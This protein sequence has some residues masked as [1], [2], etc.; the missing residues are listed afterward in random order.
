MQKSC[1]LWAE[2]WARIIPYSRSRLIVPCVIAS[3]V[4][5]RAPRAYVRSPPAAA[6][7]VPSAAP[8]AIRTAFT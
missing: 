4:V 3:R 2:T 6:Y 7:R 5:V 1:A 8:R